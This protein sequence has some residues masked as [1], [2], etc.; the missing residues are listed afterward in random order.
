LTKSLSNDH[1]YLAKQRRSEV[2]KM[3]FT[4]F[5]LGGKGVFKEEL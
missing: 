3:T 2:S 5:D 4:A 1:L